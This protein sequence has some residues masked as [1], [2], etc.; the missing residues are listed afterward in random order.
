MTKKIK[1][2]TPAELKEYYEHKTEKAYATAAKRM[3]RDLNTRIDKNNDWYQLNSSEFKNHISE[4]CKKYNIPDPN[5]QVTNT[6]NAQ[7]ISD[8]QLAVQNATQQMTQN[9]S[10]LTVTKLPNGDYDIH[11]PKIQ[12]EYLNDVVKAAYAQP[13]GA[14]KSE[15]SQLSAQDL[16]SYY[17]MLLEVVKEYKL[18]YPDEAPDTTDWNLQ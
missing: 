9:T 16:T 1:D 4:L 2:M 17:L 6:A 7:I 15:F 14:T 3:I 18:K 10:H 8:V 11:L 5:N 12:V 13:A